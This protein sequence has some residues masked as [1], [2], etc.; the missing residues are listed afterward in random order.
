[1]TTGYFARVTA[2]TETRLWINN[3]TLEE[4]DLAI[5][6]GAI[7]CTTNPA[8]CA[9]L[10]DVEPE[11]IQALI[12]SVLVRVPDD[13]EAAERVYHLAAK[14]VIDRFQPLHTSSGGRYGFVTVQGDPRR[15]DDAD[16]IVNEALRHAR[17]GPC[18]MAKIPVTEA[19]TAAIEALV[20]RNI[21]I[22][23]TEIFALA[24][25]RYICDAFARAARRTGN[26]PPLFVTHI[27]GIFDEYLAG[28]V[29]THGIAIAQEVVGQAGWIV[30]H[31]Q[32]RAMKAGCYPGIMLGGGARGLHHFTEMV[33]GD[34]HITINWSTAQALIEAAGPV[35]TRIHAEAPADMV[36]ELTAKLPDFQRAFYEDALSPAEFKDFGPLQ[37]FR[38]AFLKGYG[39]LVAAV[40]TRRQAALA[41][42]T[43]AVG[44]A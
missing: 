39:R 12:D 44:Q 21:P 43:S 15:D 7:N 30:A 8:F 33:G 23:A 1:M 40:T 24:Q 3:P 9:R 32:Y 35:V 22:C 4:C 34:M 38:A 36:A 14:R 16:F 20:A 11:P 37:H 31:A 28:Y 25:A 6:A 41:G 18:F 42:A 2:E 17:L 19:G 27:T 5:D 26:R 29:R 13:D 10:L